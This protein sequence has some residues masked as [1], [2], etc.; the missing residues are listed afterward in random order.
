FTN[1]ARRGPPGQPELLAAERF[2]AV[3]RAGGWQI[4]RHDFVRPEVPNVSACDSAAAR[5][6]L[7]EVCAGL[8]VAC[9]EGDALP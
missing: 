2:D 5:D 3:E 7:A 1:V 4:V 9:A 6:A 8:G